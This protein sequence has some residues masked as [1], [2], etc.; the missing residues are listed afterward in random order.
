MNTFSFMATERNDLSDFNCHW[1]YGKEFNEH[2]HD[3]YEIIINTLGETTHTING[4]KFLQS[5]DDNFVKIV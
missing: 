4:V 5:V 1:W 2:S 3:F